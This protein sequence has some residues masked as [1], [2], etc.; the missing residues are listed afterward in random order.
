VV[1]LGEATV[2]DVDVAMPTRVVVMP[3]RIHLRGV[4]NSRC[5]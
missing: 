1:E 3:I 4:L 5:S 2:G